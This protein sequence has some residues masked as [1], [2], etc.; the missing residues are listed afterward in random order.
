MELLCLLLYFCRQLNSIEED[1]PIT[2]TDLADAQ[3]ELDD[4]TKVEAQLSAKVTKTNSFCFGK[5]YEFI[6]D[7]AV[8]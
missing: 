7:I 8:M 1:I 4:V 3:K 5:Y 6:N 2:K